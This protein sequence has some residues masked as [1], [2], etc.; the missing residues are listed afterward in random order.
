[1]SKK[2]DLKTLCKKIRTSILN[3]SLAAGASSSHF[4]GSL[5]TVEI[6]TCLFEEIMKID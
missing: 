6:L 5:S 4:G 1:M 3:T 2:I